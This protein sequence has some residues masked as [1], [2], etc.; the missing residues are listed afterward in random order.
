MLYGISPWDA[1]TL[2]G[3]PAIVLTIS[4]AASLVPAMRAA[5]LEPVE[6]LRQD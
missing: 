4:A 3:V 1:V 6:V 5:R 2:A